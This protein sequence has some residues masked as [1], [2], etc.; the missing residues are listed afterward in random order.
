MKFILFFII[1]L[2][3][4]TTSFAQRDPH[5]DDVSCYWHNQF[6]RLHKVETGWL[7]SNSWGYIVFIPTSEQNKLDICLD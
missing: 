1:S 4:T 5:A 2:F 7:M 6:I 3:I